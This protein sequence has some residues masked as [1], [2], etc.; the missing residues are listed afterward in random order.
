MTGRNRYGEPSSVK[1]LL[2]QMIPVALAIMAWFAT[3]MTSIAVMQ[4]Q[5]RTLQVSVDKLS[6]TVGDANL[7]GLARDHEWFR[8]H[9]QGEGP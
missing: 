9:V 4:E 1:P 7:G 3:S 2:I 6:A 5:V 8:L